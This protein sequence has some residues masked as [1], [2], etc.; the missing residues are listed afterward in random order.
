MRLRHRVGTTERIVEIRGGHDGLTGHTI[1]D[2]V[3]ALSVGEPDQL[4]GLDIDGRLHHLDEPLAPITLWE[5]SLLVAHYRHET[6]SPTQPTSADA[7]GLPDGRPPMVVAVSGGLRAGEIHPLPAQREDWLVGRSRDCTLRL[8]DPAVSLRHAKI[9]AGAGER[10]RIADLGSH[11]GT[12]VNAEALTRPAVVPA[13]AAVRVGATELH[14]RPA[15][16]D[17]HAAARVGLGANAGRV[18]FNRPPRRRPPLTPASLPV[19]AKPP[20]QPEPEPLSWA[21]IVLPVV[22]GLVL[23]LVWSPFMA[24]FAVLGPLL[25]VATWQERKRRARKAHTRACEQVAAR[26]RRLANALPAVWAAERRRR[27][28]ILPD[29]AEICRRAVALSVRCW[30]RRLNDPDA[31]QLGVGTA[32]LAFAPRLEARDSDPQAE[33]GAA[34]ASAKPTESRSVQRPGAAAPEAVEAVRAMGALRCVPVPVSL[35]AGE[36]VGIVGPP[37]VA[38]SIARCLIVQAA[39]LHGPADLAVA[40]LASSH[41]TRATDEDRAPVLQEGAC[42]TAADWTQAAQSPRSCGHWSWARWLPHC[43]DPAG[44]RGALVANGLR[45]ANGV[46]EALAAERSR[47]LRLVVIE[48]SELL[49]GRAAA[50]RAALAL[51]RV[52]GIVTTADAHDLPASCSTVVEIDHL[53]GRVRLIDPRTSAVLEPV[54]GW[55]MTTRIAAC[56]TAALA[57]LDDP[58]WRTAGGGLPDQVSLLDLVGGP[59]NAQQL[60]AHWDSLPAT[61]ALATPIGADAQGATVIDLVA[62]GPHL[63]VGGTTGSGKSEL[64]RTLVAGLA[65]AAP[66]EQVAFV[67]VDY[68][69]GAAFDRCAQLPHTAGMVTDLDDRL[70]ERALLCLEAELRYRETRLREAGVDDLAAYHAQHG[71]TAHAKARAADPA[72]SKEPLPRL[73]VVVDEFATLAAELPGF[74]HSLVGVAQRGRSLGV[75]LVLATQRPAGVVTEDIRANTSCRVALRVTDRHDSNDVIGAPDAAD[76]PRGRPGRALARFGPGELTGFQAALVTGVTPSAAAG[77]RVVV[78]DQYDIDD[79]HAIDGDH[80]AIPADPSPA[81]DPADADPSGAAA[82]TAHANGERSDLDLIVE[83][84]Q[85]AHRLRGGLPPRSPWPAPLPDQL[86]VDQLQQIAARLSHASFGGGPDQ[87]GA[88]ELSPQVE[89]GEA[90]A[91]GGASKQDRLAAWLVDDPSNQR[92]YS[93]GW[94]PAD[95]HLVVI[96]APGSGTSTTLKMLAL[97]LCRHASPSRLHVH[98]ID[99]DAGRLTQLE[100][101]P[102]VGTVA[103]PSDSERRIRLLRYLDDE[104]SARRALPQGCADGPERPDLVLLVDDLAGLAR[105]HDPVRETEPHQQFAR[106]WS[107]G[108]AVGVRV[109]VSAGRAADL[110]AELAASAG[111]VLVHNTAEIG[112]ALRFGLRAD[113]TTLNPGR[114]LRGAD[115]VEVQVALPTPQDLE[116]AAAQ[117][118]TACTGHGDDLAAPVKIG[119]LPEVVGAGD[120]PVA[121]EITAHRIRLDFAMCELRLVPTGFD[122]HNG[123][124]ALVLGPARTGRT[125]ALAAMAVAA[126]NAGAQIVVVSD[127]PHSQLAQILGLEPTTLSDLSRQCEATALAGATALDDAD[128]FSDADTAPC[129]SA[130][131]GAAESVGAPTDDPGVPAFRRVVLLDN[132]ERVEDHNQV[133]VGLLNNPDTP[134]HVIAA[135]SADRLRSCYGHWLNEMRACRTGV[136]LRPGPLDGDL[137]GVTLPPRIVPARHPGRCIIASG[138]VATAAQIACVRAPSQRVESP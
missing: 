53:C 40:V 31:M 109:A 36:V 127:T 86:S 61:S 123:E 57:R 132:A 29:P 115:G 89:V 19:P 90:G 87:L 71:A 105:H 63:L 46:V 27:I 16:S 110:P 92:Q 83:A 72:P 59:P 104:I 60:A 93:D 65:L 20:D 124:H 81:T 51:S 100:S 96:G 133:L 26:V 121:G 14:F 68:K 113:T 38:R 9:T 80:G 130:T 106:I 125:S 126:R 99:L 35:R 119:V 11:N 74:L 44:G 48:G 129:D 25:S 79:G 7:P 2:L 55:G 117:H 39:V 3:T 47:R 43:D 21:G 84:A 77:L 98:V 101:L 69:G 134:T 45:A 64:L 112:D 66:P 62:D 52:A 67:L 73:V 37:A 88:D 32:D 120:L 28:T 94:N 18:P 111:V 41:K 76:I 137:L 136:L 1:A 135:T 108:P 118:A 49:A 97:D 107:N 42:A 138:G 82:Q 70:A 6:A 8:G 33:S 91:A 12:F 4:V 102:Q 13:A 17:E 128:G 75:H 24:V 23:A 56:A 131:F 58:E 50:G 114:A 103:R 34:A 22:V 54:L 116:T 30:E 10:P 95:G 85:G 5:G 78:Q 15:I 122:L